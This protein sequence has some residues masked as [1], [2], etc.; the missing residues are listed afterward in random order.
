MIRA[1]EEEYRE[2]TMRSFLLTALAGIT[3]LSQTALAG[4]PPPSALAVA[5]F[6]QD[7]ITDI[8]AEK[9]DA[10]QQGLLKIALI[11]SAT[12]EQV[13]TEYPIRLQDGYAFL[14]VGKFDGNA[15]GQTQIAARKV[16]GD[17]GDLEVGGVRLWDLTDDAST[18]ATPA[19]GNLEL[20]P[21]PVYSLVGIG[22]LDG[23]GVDD[24]VFVQGDCGVVT[25]CPDPGL[26][27]VYLMDSSMQLMKIAHP[28]IVADDPDVEV[29]GVADANGDGNADVIV[30]NTTNRSLRI[31]L[32]RSDTDKGIAV[33]DQAFAFH[34]PADDYDFLGFALVDPGGQADLVFATNGAAQERSLVVQRIQPDPDDPSGL[35]FELSPLYGADIENGFDYAGNGLFDGDTETDLVF[36]R[37]DG[38][39]E[40]QLRVLLLDLDVDDDGDIDA[41]DQLAKQSKGSAVSTHLDPDVWEQ[42]TTG[43]VIFP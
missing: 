6:N 15:E 16:S 18:T 39:D 27:R 19:S 34:L 2:Q 32:M 3:A 14:A 25:D 29:L 5:D 22:D 9:V 38:A 37:S 21:D 13:G 33:S 24:F 26:I 28:L 31:F 40:G 7:G 17:S 36:R 10:P 1:G 43:A 20:L 30:A 42:R 23:N 41:V 35:V 11:D 8:L 4:P 12:S